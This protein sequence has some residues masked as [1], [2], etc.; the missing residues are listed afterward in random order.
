MRLRHRRAGFTLV[1]LAIVVAILGLLAATAVPLFQRYQLRTKRSEAFAN[2]VSIARSEESYFAAT[3]TYPATTTAWPGG[4]LG[5]NKRAWNAAAEADFAVIGFR[6]E[7]NVYFDYDVFTGCGC[8]N[9]Y[10]ASAYADIDADGLVVA[11]MYVKPS[12]DGSPECPSG[13]IPALTTPIENGSP[14]YSQVSWN[15]TSDDF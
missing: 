13:V 9:C 4:G 8:T 3:G 14:V 1:E 2:L 5:G 10:T 7:G 6:P 12:S 15:T 11:L